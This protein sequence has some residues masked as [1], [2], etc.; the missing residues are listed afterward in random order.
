[1]ERARE[2]LRKMEE[3]KAKTDKWR[4]NGIA[5]VNREHDRVAANEVRIKAHLQRRVREY[6]EALLA[7]LA[8]ESP[9]P[10]ATKPGKARLSDHQAIWWSDGL[11]QIS[12]ALFRE[13]EL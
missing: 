5:Y 6:A 8:E 10:D 7:V 2:N 9:R 4:V 13:R 12:T 3:E 11:L 1:M